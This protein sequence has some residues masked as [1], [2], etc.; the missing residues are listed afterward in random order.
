M[1]LVIPASGQDFPNGLSCDS[2]DPRADAAIIAS[3]REKMD[4]IHRTQHRP[5][6]ALVLSGGGAKG[7]SHVG[8]MRYL[9]EEGI[10]VDMICGTSIGGLIGAMLSLGYDSHFLD[11][12]MRNQDWMQMLTD[13]I[14]P[15]YYSFSRKRYRETYTLSIPF[16]YSKKDFQSRIDNQVR[17]I[18]GG[19]RSPLGRNDL[20]SSLP[21][22]Y[23]YGFNVNNLISSVTVGY[24]DYQ[25]FDE[26]PIPFFCVAADL[27]SLKAKNWS[28]GSI[29]DAMR[30]TMSIPGLFKPVRSKG[31]ILVDGG[32]RNNFPVDL[33]RA[34][35]ADIVIGVDLSDLDLSYSQVNNLGD[36]FMQFMSMLGRNSFDKN[37]GETDVFIKPS[38]SEYNMLS[39][40]AEAIDTMINRGY[41]AARLK[42]E[43]LSEVKG[44]TKGAV[45]TLQHPR[46]VDINTTP[47]QISSVE[48]QGLTNSE[49]R[50]LHRK[51]KLQAGSYVT[52]AEMQHVM[53]IIQATG[54]FSSVTYNLLGHEAPYRLVFDCVKGPRHQFGMG[55]RFDTEEWPS[56]LF[57]VGMNAHKLS[58]AKLD[59][60]AKVGR[61]QRFGITGSLDL[62]WIPTI[63][64]EAYIRNITS[65]LST[66]LSQVGDEARWWGHY[67]KLYLSNIRWTSVDFKFGAQFRQ[68]NLPYS[69]TYGASVYRI[70][71]D[72]ARGGYLG[73]FANGAIYTYDRYNYP[74]KG[75]NLTF[76]YDYDF[77]KSRCASFKPLHT[78]YLNFTPIV[79]LGSRLALIPDIHMR[80]LFGSPARPDDM[81]PVD[82]SYSLAH[83]NYVGGNMPDRFIEGQMPFIG[84]GGAYQAGP[85]AATVNL[86]LRLRIG[87]NL[88]ITP[89][90]GYFRE[91]D[92]IGGFVETL[93][94]T[95]WG[96]GL[97]IGYN[98]PIGPVKAI[99]TW[100]DR[101]HTFAQDAGLYVSFGFDF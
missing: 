51:I 44:L 5:T 39:F 83:Q 10:P 58:G 3:M 101:F 28:S 50:L 62:A 19:A 7:A 40:N 37:V 30:S 63:N 61:N 35:G 91:A 17:Y 98:T 57:N 89:T 33:A 95:L 13:R 18:D 64:V 78:A 12:L 79:P 47:V 36:I 59:I 75:V 90:G 6:V 77:R 80:A 21:S 85:Y 4:S 48:F 67:E 100:S 81:S 23:V 88:F 93:L 54:C 34:M 74:S 14:D 70:S 86:G 9:E 60:N 32:T 22:G 24:Q 46:A 68:F 72:L 49:S 27:V 92:S 76:G 94:P 96:A 11:S 41:A 65:T 69:T 2:V 1:L 99:G 82:P 55:A 71:Y 26:L 38:I 16:Y 25:S 29:K 73:L 42:A 45:T 66:D 97:E 15:S 31:T 43:E 20:A 56:F 84:F 87:K 8:V 53:S 52:K